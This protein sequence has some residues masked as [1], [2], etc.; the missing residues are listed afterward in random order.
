[1]RNFLKRKIA[2]SQLHRPLLKAVTLHQ[3]FKYKLAKKMKLNSGY[4]PKVICLGNFKTGTVSIAAILGSKLYGQHEPDAYLYC[5]Q[6]LK[7]KNREID[8][9]E[10]IDFLKSR[11][12][13]LR[14][15]Y[16][17]SGFLTIE[18]DSLINIFPKTKFILTIRH[19]KSWVKSFLRHILNNRKRLDYHYWEPAFLYYFSDTVFPKEEQVLADL[20]LFPLRSLLN[21]WL[22]SNESVLKHIPDEQLLLI[23]TSE[24]SGSLN[25]IEQFMGWPQNTLNCS[26]T[27]LHSSKNRTDPLECISN[28]YLETIFLPYEEKFN[29][30]FLK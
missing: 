1:M 4:Q 24:L 8:T 17:S 2:A 13:S 19:P 28:D 27:H 11:F 25:K 21:Y 9:Q 15:D 5:Q 10:W 29:S 30:L 16:E 18:S 6:W 3:L 22:E 12:H 23:E 26:N 7:L 20:N 14:L